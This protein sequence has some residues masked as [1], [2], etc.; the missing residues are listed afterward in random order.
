V[1]VEGDAL[2][3]EF[4]QLP[5]DAL[6][7]GYAARTPRRRTTCSSAAAGC[8]SVALEMRDT[9][10]QILDSTRPTRSTSNSHNTTSS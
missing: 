7:D 5:D 9:Q 10:L 6:F 2:V 1:R 8:G 4:A 3:Q